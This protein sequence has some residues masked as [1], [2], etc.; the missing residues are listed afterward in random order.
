MRIPRF[1]AVIAVVAL[2]ASCARSHTAAP[3]AKPSITK[4]SN[5]L[6]VRG[7]AP[8]SMSVDERP[9]GVNPEGQWQLLAT[10]HFFDAQGH[11]T[12]IFANSDLN[13]D[14]SRG[15]VQWQNRMRFGQP[16]SIV[17]VDTEGPVVLRVHPNAPKMSDVVV[18]TDT[19]SWNGPRIAVGAIGPY[20]AQIGWFPRATAPVRIKRK[21][22]SGRWI[23]LATLPT[24]SSSYRDATVHPGTTY[25][26]MVVRTDTG[27]TD[28]AQIRTPEGLSKTSL[29]SVTGVGLW[30]VFTTNPSED[31]YYRNLDVNAIVS[32]AVS[33]HVH[34]VELRTAY[35]AMWQITPESKPTID[36]IIDGLRAHDIAVIGWTVPRA[37]AF[38]DLQTAVKMAT[39][40]TGSGHHFDGIAVDAERG[41]EFM[42]DG[43]DAIAKYYHLLRMALGP[44]YLIV[45]T[46]EDPEL[47]HLSETDYPYKEIA[48]FADVFQPMS[49]WRMRDGVSTSEQVRALLK[50]SYNAVRALAGRPVP[51]NVGAQISAVGRNGAP[52][53]EEIGA[54]LDEAKELGALGICFF[55]WND[56]VPQQWSA[57]RLHAW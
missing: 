3:L 37:V 26:Y 29:S 43:R 23:T 50:R 39:Y 4:L 49:Y 32:Q 7:A 27:I 42:A 38:D 46:I 1:V 2:C 54:S 31:V 14:A 36:A 13:W 30:L 12:L 48:E 33:A 6:V 56:S 20:L 35:G 19:R 52:T 15:V 57:I 40:R 10:A 18:K 47:E 17:S 22:E 24:S 5:G 51:I 41:E 34:F 11:R 53:P 45:A 21:E 44:R 55:A 28:V 16:S 8:V 9:L 25:R